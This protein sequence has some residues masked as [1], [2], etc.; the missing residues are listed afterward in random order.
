MVFIPISEANNSN[1][2][3]NHGWYIIEEADEN[4]ND[5]EFSDFTS[6]VYSDV[7][8]TPKAVNQ[9]M[10]EISGSVPEGWNFS[11]NEYN[12]RRLLEMDSGE[13]YPLYIYVYTPGIW[14]R[15]RNG[16]IVAI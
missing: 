3:H 7:F 14:S 8:L 11:Y 4:Y 5:H 15:Q 9:C 10:A 6:M 1:I 12:A 16:Y 13:K 2:K